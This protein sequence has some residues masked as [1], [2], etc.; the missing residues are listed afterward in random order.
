MRE[1]G[2]KPKLSLNRQ[3]NQI[4]I[5]YRKSAF[6]TFSHQIS[7]RYDCNRGRDNTKC[8]PSDDGPQA[9]SRTHIVHSALRR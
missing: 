4:L 1:Y 8:Y 7:N 9:T 6:A 5:K 3:L 2:R